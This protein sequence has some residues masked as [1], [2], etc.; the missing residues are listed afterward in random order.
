MSNRYYTEFKQSKVSSTAPR[1]SP[2][3]GSAPQP[4]WSGGDDPPYEANIG[5]GGPDMN[6]ATNFTRV[7]AHV[8]AKMSP[9][10]NPAGELTKK[11]VE[12]ATPVGSGFLGQ[13]GRRVTAIIDAATGK[14]KE[15]PPVRGQ[16]DL[17]QQID[18]LMKQKGSKHKYS[19]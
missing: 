5:P 12:E 10:E 19:K 17:D 2:G 3:L 18:D 9:E 1:P 4:S 15:K 16:R 8:K 13:I 6:R 14:K 11:I 7:P